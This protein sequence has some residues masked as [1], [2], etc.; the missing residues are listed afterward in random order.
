MTD[1]L[2]TL[3]DLQK[4]YEWKFDTYNAL[5]QEAIKWVKTLEKVEW[6]EPSTPE[7]YKNFQ[8]DEFMNYSEVVEFIKHFFNLTEEELK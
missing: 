6:D 7:E 3:K 5:R 4:E 1:E 8:C 2:K